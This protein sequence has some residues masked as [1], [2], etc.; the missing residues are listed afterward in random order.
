MNAFYYAL[1]NRTVKS[2][3]C[4]FTEY[5]SRGQRSFAGS[6]SCSHHSI[7]P[8][9]HHLQRWPSIKPVFGRVAAGVST[10]KCYANLANK[11]PWII[12]ELMLAHRLRRWP[13]IKRMIVQRLVFAGLETHTKLW[14]NV[15]LML[16]HRLRRW[17]NIESTLVQRHAFTRTA[18]A[19]LYH[20]LFLTVYKRVN[21]LN[22]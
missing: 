3:V 8:N 2:N 9:V 4:V 7:M 17:P 10:N 5:T 13:N 15:D 6:S 18:T 11:M 21:N 19:P 14:T 16:G 22:L 12:I 20:W 1:Q